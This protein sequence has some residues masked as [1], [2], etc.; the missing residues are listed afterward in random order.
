MCL[1]FIFV[2]EVDWKNIFYFRRFVVVVVEL[3]F[4]LRASHLLHLLVRSCT[5]SATVPT[6]EKPLM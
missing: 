5:T 1:K 6:L 4:R 2:A 3:G